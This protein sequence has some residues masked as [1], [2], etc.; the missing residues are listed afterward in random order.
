MDELRVQ[1]HGIDGTAMDRMG[2]ERGLRLPVREYGRYARPDHALRMQAH[3]RW[4]P[5]PELLVAR[6]DQPN[7]C[8]LPEVGPWGSRL[9]A[10][11]PHRHYKLQ[12]PNAC[13]PGKRHE[14]SGFQ[15]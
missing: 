1:S 7:I 12:L 14:R 15:C 9:V 5:G 6:D 13:R 3:G 2:A 10:A 11:R 4:H 8:A